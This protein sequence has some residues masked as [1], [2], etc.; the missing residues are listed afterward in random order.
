LAIVTGAS[1]GIGRAVALRLARDGYDVAFT[2]RGRHAPARRVE[3]ELRAVG[4]D[5]RF[6]Q[7]GFDAELGILEAK[8]KRLLAAG[9]PEVL[10]NNAAISP[11]AT[12]LE[13]RPSDWERTMRV[14]VTAPVLLGQLAARAMIDAGVAGRIVN[15]TSILATSALERCGAYCAS[16]AALAIA[17]RVQALELVE[18]GIR[19]NAVAPG[20]TAT[21]M[22]YGDQSHSLTPAWQS[23][24]MRR[25][26]RAEEIAAAVAFLVSPQASYVTGATVTVDG[27]LSLAAGP[28]ALQNE[29][30]LPPAPALPTEP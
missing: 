20:H 21:P 15:I 18:H 22:N 16:K 3:R 26:A 1:V 13:E 12:F 17:T 4:A 24:P 28:S 10:V 25:A 27:G 2:Y 8:A 7:L 30:G 23:I 11:R 19:V 14:N 9:T 29:M 5:V 6:S